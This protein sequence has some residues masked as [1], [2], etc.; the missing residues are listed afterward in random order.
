MPGQS[1]SV[2]PS[3]SGSAGLNGAPADHGVLPMSPYPIA[4]RDPHLPPYFLVKG[5]HP[6]L[7]ESRRGTRDARSMGRTFVYTEDISVEAMKEKAKHVRK[8][9]I[10]NTKSRL[11]GLVKLEG[12]DEVFARAAGAC[13]CGCQDER[14]SLVVNEQML[15]ALPNGDRIV[16]QLDAA[17]QRILGPKNQRTLSKSVLNSETGTYTGGTAFERSGNAHP[18][19]GARAYNLGIG[20]EIPT[21]LMAPSAGNKGSPEQGYSEGLSMRK[22]IQSAAIELA[23]AGT[24]YLGKAYCEMM[25]MQAELVNAPRIGTYRNTCFG[26]TQLNVSPAVA[27]DD[28][29]TDL[30]EHLG[31]FGGPHFDGGDSVSGLSGMVSWPDLP[32]GYDP[33]TFHL[34][35]L[36]AYVVL[37]GLNMLYFNGLR[38]HGG[39]PPR[40]PRG[41]EV[42]N[43]AYRLVV[44][45]YPPSVILENHGITAL[46]ALRSGH[47]AGRKG[48]GMLTLDPAVKNNPEDR[49]QQAW[50][51]HATFAADGHVIMDDEAVVNYMARSAYLLSV[52]SMAQLPPHVKV[53]IDPN[54]FLSAFSFEQDGED[55]EVHP[56][57]VAPVLNDPEH[58]YNHA[59]CRDAA[60]WNEHQKRKRVFIPHS[61]DDSANIKTLAIRSDPNAI[62]SG[63]AGRPPKYAYSS[64]NHK[65]RHREDGRLVEDDEDVDDEERDNAQPGPSMSIASRVIT[66][67]DNV[68]LS[69]AMEKSAKSTRETFSATKAKRKRDGHEDD[70]ANDGLRRSARRARGDQS[71][72]HTQDTVQQQPSRARSLPTLLATTSVRTQ[73][74]FEV[75]IKGLIQSWAIPLNVT[76]AELDDVHP[77]PSV[78]T[79]D[80]MFALPYLI[81]EATTVA[82]ALR[83]LA[84]HPV[85]ITVHQ[86]AT[87]L[88]VAHREIGSFRWKNPDTLDRIMAAWRGWDHLS[89]VCAGSD[90]DVRHIKATLMQHHAVF[91]TWLECLCLCYS[92]GSDTSSSD[93]LSMLAGKIS[94]LITMRNPSTLIPHDYHPSFTTTPCAISLPKRDTDP[95]PNVDS[96]FIHQRRVYNVMVSLLSKWLGFPQRTE[97]RLQAWL[98]SAMIRLFTVDVLSLSGTFELYDNI[99]AH[100]GPIPPRPL[101]PLDLAPILTRLIELPLFDATSRE[102]IATRLIAKVT[103]AASVGEP[104]SLSLEQQVFLATGGFPVGPLNI[105][106]VG[107]AGWINLDQTESDI[108]PQNTTEAAPSAFASSSH[109]TLDHL[110]PTLFVSPTTQSAPS[111][112]PQPLNLNLIPDTIEIFPII[113]TAVNALKMMEYLIDGPTLRGRSLAPVPPGLSAWHIRLL[114]LVAGNLDKYLP[115]REKAPGVRRACTSHGPYAPEHVRTRAGFFSSLVFRTFLFGGKYMFDYPLIFDNP[116]KLVQ[117]HASITASTNLLPN[118]YFTDKMAYGPPTARNIENTPALWDATASHIPYNFIAQSHSIA[119]TDFWQKVVRRVHN[120]RP[121]PFCGD[122]MGYLVTADYVYTG[123]VT[124]PTVD[125]TARIIWTLRRGALRGLQYLHLI[126]PSIEEFTNILH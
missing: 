120:R 27:D 2:S 121:Y 94:T 28:A 70:T 90:L 105:A 44:V 52:Y 43:S 20:Y 25:A 101:T 47:N 119:F 53:H 58:P 96:P 123:V 24:T 11:R 99:L 114:E 39:T 73:S 104:A 107:A 16:E 89:A 57:T 41:Q 86:S 83:S 30:T 35:E 55:R 103:Q 37:D 75:Q 48:H 56:W 124:M 98:V 68:K 8:M 82:A 85:G 15:R 77:S 21:Q 93:G 33:G 19:R 4:D 115:F 51:P 36:G 60:S 95:H 87:Q 46:A 54:K 92:Q 100:T 126:D 64:K 78:T 62:P 50:T 112:P 116:E 106:D 42:V 118:N 108:A 88:T 109:L 38:L 117:D 113:G 34:I 66:R 32:A 7:D 1:P 49:S 59:R 110:P 22:E 91:Y 79:V 3:V 5:R 111:L 40:A 31:D 97:A 67:R 71:S 81:R 10:P 12:G 69:G 45:C 63:I 13:A 84:G 102:A 122:L 76:S 61:Y 29:A 18:V 80:Y 26:N 9:K 72:S 65:M 74:A 6:L 14:Q 17:R 125:E 23:S